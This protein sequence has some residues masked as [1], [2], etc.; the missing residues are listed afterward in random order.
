VSLSDATWIASVKGL[1]AG[2]VNLILAY[3]L[4]ATTPP[5]LN[6]AAA[7]ALG[8]FAYGVSLALFVVGLRHLGTARTGAYF[9]VAPFFGAVLALAMGEP[10][11]LQLLIAGALMAFGIWL[12]L[13]ERHEHK[14][15]HETLGH[16]HEHEH[17]E[18]HQHAHCIRKAA[19]INCCWVR[20]RSIEDWR[21]AASL[22]RALLPPRRAVGAVANQ[23]GAV[24]D[25]QMLWG[26]TVGA[27]STWCGNKRSD[28][29]TRT[30][31]MS[32]SINIF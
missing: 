15:T 8:L 2:S 19:T 4:G 25:W 9:S 24:T 5:L 26:R 18:H 7:M 31:S 11:T 22:S 20:C 28:S 30:S 21:S 14:H 23:I 17:E 1:A 29:V 6:A 3:A 12:H 10:V 13:T 16:E 27:L 32:A